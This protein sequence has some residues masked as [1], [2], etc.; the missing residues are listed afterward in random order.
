MQRSPYSP[1]RIERTGIIAIFVVFC[2]PV[3]LPENEGAVP[4]GM[5]M[6][7]EG[8]FRMGSN[9]TPS[10]LPARAGPSEG[11]CLDRHKGAKG[12]IQGIH[13]CE[14]GVARRTR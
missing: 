14:A 2:V 1:L 10:E 6:I 9:S 4:E 12:P 5:A 3:V 8:E 7:I 13:P 11:A